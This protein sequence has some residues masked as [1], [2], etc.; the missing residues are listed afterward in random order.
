MIRYQSNL[1]AVILLLLL[2]LAIAQLPATPDEDEEIPYQLREE[3][4]AV[5]KR[6][7]ERLY[8]EKNEQGLHFQRGGY[9][10]RFEKVDDDTYRVIF[11]KDTV[12]DERLRTERFRLT[13]SNESGKWAI[14]DEE[15]QS[16]YEEMIRDKPGDEKFYTFDR[17]SFEREGLKVTATGGA[18][19]VDYLLA[20]PDSVIFGASQLS[21]DYAPPVNLSYHQNQLYAQLQQDH[22]EDFAFTPE[23]VFIRCDVKTCEELFAGE[24][25]GMEEA[26]VESLDRELQ[27]FYKE[28]LHDQKEDRKERPFSGFRIPQRPDH[29]TYSVAI[30]RNERD[31]WIQLSYDN[32]SGWETEFGASGYGRLYGYP[33]QETL[34]K[35][36]APHEIEARQ[37]YDS[38]MYSVTSVDGDIEVGLEDAE[39]LRADVRYGLRINEPT[40]V[41][42]FY[43]ADIDGTSERKAQKRA[44]LTLNE[45]EDE[46]DRQLVYVRRGGSGGYI[47]FPEE[48]QPGTE[49]ELRMA[50]ETRGSIHKVNP[51]YAYVSRGAWLPLVKYEEKIPDFNLTVRSPSR[52]KALGVGELISEQKTGDVVTTEWAAHGVHFPTIIF[53]DYFEG[54]PGK[55]QK[56]DGAEIPVVAHADKTTMHDIGIKAKQLENLTEQ[57]VNALNIYSKLYGID[58]PHAKLDLV[59]DPGGGLGAQAP[60]SIVYVGGYSF[61]SEAWLAERVTNPGSLSR[62]L[63]TLV[64]HEVGHQWWGG[65]VGP[66]NMRNY[67]FV[68]SLAEYSSALFL[69]IIESDGYTNPEKGK[70]A[71][72]NYVAG[73]RKEI[74]ETDLL[75]SVQDARVTWAGPTGGWV[76]AL[77]AKGPY[78]FH[79]LRETFGSGH[80]PAQDDRFFL[81][82]K[83]MAQELSGRQIVTRDIQRVAEESF[84]GTMEWFFDQW[85]R[86]VGVPEYSFNYSYRLAEDGNYIVEGNVKQRVVAGQK[87]RELD[88]I[89][90]RG[91][92]PITVLGRDKQEYPA[93]LLVEGSETPFAFKVPVEPLEI[94]LNKY[95]EIL[96]HPPLENRSW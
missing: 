38:R 56:S 20:E 19:V 59:T 91:I 83:S 78:A 52:Y 94:E 63:D 12:S 81:F 15:L 5:L 55:A 67:W 82:L 88:D 92:V 89:F 69:E 60:D 54:R 47:V 61:R 51:S 16:S 45:L 29:R 36:I 14:T 25:Q 21:Y 37:D 46:R 4:E 77:Y 79:I 6:K 24:F 34:A 90:Y 65:L 66:V 32:E 41:L 48:L 17:F 10:K 35:G 95:G 86:G 44:S 68:E 9:G 18:M 2:V 8:D 96:A 58:Y 22:P 73:W 30:K 76:T 64:A 1:Y 26:T 84:G 3:L 13:L 28:W 70:K 87:K 11:I 39:L 27:N 93:R 33:A 75:A 7:A 50:Y 40:R 49:L 42:P 80:P 53:G 43:L 72:R 74:L 62:R 71:Y 31:Q 85:I 57:A 23:F